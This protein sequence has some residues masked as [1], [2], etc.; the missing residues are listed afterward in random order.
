MSYDL[1]I[2]IVSW[3][4]RDLL[5][6]CLQSVYATAQDCSFEVIVVDNASSDGS[7]DMVV[8]EFS[9]V[10]I[11][12]NKF[13]KGFGAA[14]NQGVQKATGEYVLFLNDD[15]KVYDHTFDRCLS[16][17]R[18]HTDSGALGCHIIN[19]DGST[20]PS[21]RAE[22]T[23]YSQV[24][25]LSKVYNIFP[26]LLKTYRQRNF[27]YSKTQS[28]HEVMG[29]FFMMPKELFVQL[30]GFDEHFFVWFEETDLA[31]RIR[32]AQKKVVYFADAQILHHRGAS[33]L[34][35]PTITKQR[36]FNASMLHYFKKHHSAASYISVL[37][38]SWI[39]L[40]ITGVVALLRKIFL[41][42]TSK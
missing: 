7:V 9:E 31:K 12:Q 24:I 29:A 37:F 30:G 15:T 19:S 1:S 10:T 32:N 13:N 25:V 5:R 16:Y 3:N 28:V 42:P 6:E 38:F 23:L 11:I 33:F 21:V 4:V 35:H 36:M 40:A 14:N 18:G 8:G 17:M 41:V 26:Q 27:D 2:I 22:P 34:Q 39:S 20:Q